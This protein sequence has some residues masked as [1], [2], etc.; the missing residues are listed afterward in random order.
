MS[1]AGQIDEARFWLERAHRTIAE[2][3]VMAANGWW[4]TC[5]SRLYYACF[6]ALSALFKQSGLPTS[7]HSG[8]RSLFFLHYVKTGKVSNEMGDLFRDLFEARR[9]GDY[10][11]R[12]G[13]DAA[14]V[15]AWIG[16]TEKFIETIEIIFEN[17]E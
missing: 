7:K 10:D 4:D 9:E 6:Y 13:F 1:D 16:Q 5:A 2:A 11:P 17:K 15:S 12:Q 3:K 14:H 8:V